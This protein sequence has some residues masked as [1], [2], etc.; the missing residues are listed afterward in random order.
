LFGI[1][2]QQNS[3]TGDRDRR[4]RLLFITEQNADLVA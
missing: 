4:L 1:K 2:R 3:I